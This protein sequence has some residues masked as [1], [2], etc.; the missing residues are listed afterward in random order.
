MLNNNYVIT[1]FADK[2]EDVTK[3]LEKM[4]RKAVRCGVLFEYSFGNPYVKSLQAGWDR[5]IRF[6]AL[7]IDVTISRV[8][9]RKNGWTPIAQ[10][11]H[12]PG[13]SENIV[14]PFWG[15]V[16]DQRWYTL[17]S[18]CD[19][20]NTN[21]ERKVTFLVKNEEGQ[22]KQVGSSCLKEYTGIDPA[23]AIFWAEASYP[24]GVERFD[25]EDFEKL[26][27]VFNTE[28]VL[29][30]AI[31]SI[32]DYGY[33]KSGEP[34]ST[35]GCVIQDLCLGKHPEE[36]ALAKAKAITKWLLDEIDPRDDKYRWYE[37][38][39]NCIPFAKLGY[40]EMKNVGYLA[41]LPVAYDR[42]MEKKRQREERNA[43]KNNSS[44][45]GTVG[46][47]LEIVVTSGRLVT[48]WYND[49]GITNMY[50]FLDKDGNI[51]IWKTSKGFN[52]ESVK[53]LK[54]TVKEHSTYNGENQTI[55]TRCKVA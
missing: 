28:R 36:E 8:W 31:E 25:E 45:V 27:K 5:H 6:D 52:A 48:S 4:G 53:T 40:V 38:E 22:L 34:H 11:Q 44:F 18:R 42:Y 24:C 14:T 16:V 54:G 37:L 3:D 20:C 1:I 41:Y 46:D 49:F 32:R 15:Q 50:K 43:Q 7:V 29:G 19:H 13:G 39:T 10:L 26:P 30:L 23:G 21:R 33:S 35:K 12:F 17:P 51:Y 47:K 9:I 2:K 55:L